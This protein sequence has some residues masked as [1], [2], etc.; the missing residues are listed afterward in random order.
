MPDPNQIVATVL[1]VLPLAAAIIQARLSRRRSSVESHATDRTPGDVYPRAPDTVRAASPSVSW[2]NMK[3]VADGDL[4]DVALGSAGN[5]LLIEEVQDEGEEPS[6][7]RFRVLVPWREI[8]AH[9]ERGWF[10]DSVLLSFR[11]FPGATLELLEPQARALAIATGAAWPFAEL[12]RDLEARNER[13][14]RGATRVL[15]VCLYGLVGVASLA[16]CGAFTWWPR[17]AE[18]AR[19]MRSTTAI[20]TRVGQRRVHYVYEVAGR[21]HQASTC[22]CCNGRQEQTGDAM[23]IY[24]DPLEPSRPRVKRPRVPVVAHWGA[25]LASFTL[26]PLLELAFLASLGLGFYRRDRPRFRPTTE[27]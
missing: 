22:L 6:T 26:V 20:V 25:V 12:A 8:S 27:T 5:Q 11:S 13:D 9:M 14:A 4:W 24:Y 21:R 1:L 16:A 18:I 15:Y 7:P 10:R 17:E 23:T 3:G 2:G 19:R